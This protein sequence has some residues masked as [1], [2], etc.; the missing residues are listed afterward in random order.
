MRRR[1]VQVR[2]ALVLGCWA[3]GLSMVRAFDFDAHDA[4]GQTAASAMDQ[5]AIKNLKRLLNGQDASDVAAWGHQADDTFPGLA[6]LHFQVHYDNEKTPHC[7][8]LKERVPSCQDNICL[9]EAVKHFYGKVLEDEGRKIVYPA[10]DYDKAEK[11][12]KFTDADSLKM[13]INL[14]GDMHQPLHVGFSTDD[15]GHAVQVKFQGKEM[16]LYDF[17]DKGISEAV[18]EQESGFWYGGFTHVRQVQS[19]FERDKELFQK[20][21]AFG[22][23][24]SWLEETVDFACK[25]A[26]THPVTGKKLVGPD[27]PAQPVE[28]DQHAYQMV[29]DKWLRQLLVAGA[30]TAIVLNDILDAK[31][32]AKL[33]EGSTV[34]TDADKAK[35]EEEK[36][37]DKKR[38]EMQKSQGR[39]VSVSAVTSYWNPAVLVK[40]L[41][42][43]AVTVPLFLAFVN[44]G[45]NPQV[46]YELL[47]K[48]VEPTAPSGG[49]GGGGKRTL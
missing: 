14:I 29:K 33:K 17:W 6:R 39:R 15:N 23:F 28:I 44:H 2:P 37:W 32:A 49:G 27:A 18:R 5:E 42:I 31:G 11:G 21:G 22:A 30:R 16:T 24:E 26:Y 10:I 7:G 47:M 4:I 1:R 34:Q 25:T 12:L 8:P 3:L 20:E 19:E 9:L 38:D 45:L 43:A 13:L 46:Y 36:E 48:Y 40:N 35:A 41:C